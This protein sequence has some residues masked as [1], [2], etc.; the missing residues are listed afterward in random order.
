MSA[1]TAFMFP[2]Q[3]S[4]VPGVLA[5]LIDEFPSAQ[6]TL[7]QLDQMCD[8]QGHAPISRLLIDPGAAS[9]DDLVA[10][11]SPDLDMALFSSNIVI[12][13]MLV[14]AGL[15]ADVVVGHSL[16]E[17]SAFTA[18]G[19]LTLRDATRLVF[20]RTTALR[21]CSIP[22]GGMVALALGRDRATH[23][24]GFIDEPSA[25]V[26][27]DNGPDQCVISGPTTALTAVE[28]IAAAAGIRA[29]R[30]RAARPFH[31]PLL[32]DA[33]ET[34]ARD[35]ADLPVAEPRIPVYSPVL[36]RYLTSAE[37]VRAWVARHLIQPVLFY[38]GLLRL[39]RDGVRRY[40]ES[41]GR[42]TL[43]A[44]VSTCLPAAAGT[45]APLRRRCSAAEFRQAV[46]SVDAAGTDAVPAATPPTIESTNG[47]RPTSFA[48]ATEQ[49]AAPAPQ[50][51]AS[52]PPASLPAADELFAQIREIYA[53][54]LGYPVDLLDADV[55]LE[56]DLGIDSIKQ[57]E[58]FRLVRQRFG[59][60]EPAAEL[61]VTSYSTLTELTE[62]LR[63][64]A[65]GAE[66][67]PVPTGGIPR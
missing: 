7:A 42:D 25:V 29:T 45:V 13:Q 31:H 61:R 57:I 38:D 53:E 32:R 55:D 52:A 1:R 48:P 58:A 65:D 12:Y 6:A 24:V 19:A 27:V 17:V 8:E 30:L 34:F 35:F 22:D 67:A 59:L 28:H 40:V 51:E 39:Y 56:A 4:Y 64:L 3:G 10:D 15:D 50:A 43:T 21:S 60:P 54:A 49:V 44:M 2:G 23:L 66:Q 37:D 16:G 46:G 62:L 11:Q 20:G 47:H 26:T 63:R 14:A 9:L 41:G 5:Q 36:G 33:A 18:A